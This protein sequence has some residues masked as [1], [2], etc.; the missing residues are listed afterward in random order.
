MPSAPIVRIVES[1]FSPED[2]LRAFM[3]GRDDAGACAN[4]VGLVRGG[5]VSA[6]ELQHYPGFTETEIARIAVEVMA[7]NDVSD[8]LIIHR[9]GRMAPGEAIVFVAALSAHRAAAF[10]A[11]ESMM[12]WLKTD[13]PF[14]KREWRGIDSSWIEPTAE[15]YARRARQDEETR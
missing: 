10:K 3:R 12:D 8:L 9:V 13:A 11:V 7:R 1:A 4:F 5:A 2:D 15:D 14:W 6:L